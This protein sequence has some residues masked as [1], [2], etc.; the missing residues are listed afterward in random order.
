MSP[1][2]V[3]LRVLLSLALVFNGIG[4]AMAAVHM[5][6]APMDAALA[7]ALASNDAAPCHEQGPAKAKDNCCH[8]AR[9]ACACTLAAANVDARLV[10][11]LAM[12]PVALATHRLDAGHRA[13]ALA[14]PIRPPI[15]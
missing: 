3:L 15:G 2:A 6:A 12:P 13:P 1:T 7:Q 4:S 14:H 5:P 11:A 10:I 9:C 8:G